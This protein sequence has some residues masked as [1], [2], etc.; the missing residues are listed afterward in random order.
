MFLIYLTTVWTKFDC[1]HALGLTKLHLEKKIQINQGAVIRR[2]VKEKLECM[3]KKT[4]LKTFF[5]S[6]FSVLLFIN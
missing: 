6:G 1:C 3:K 4:T 2:I 5:C